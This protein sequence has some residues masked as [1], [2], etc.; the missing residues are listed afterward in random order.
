MMMSRAS[1][2]GSAIA[3]AITHPQSFR[4]R[5]K[6]L[7][8]IQAAVGAV[9]VMTCAVLACA[10]IAVAALNDCRIRDGHWRDGHILG[11]NGPRE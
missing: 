8:T 11:D 3:F 10:A 2:P 1:V 7:T 4:I 5:L 6:N 9:A